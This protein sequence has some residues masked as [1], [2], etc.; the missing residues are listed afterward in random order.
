MINHNK[1][2]TPNILKDIKNPSKTD[3][4]LPP[5]IVIAERSH[6]QYPKEDGNEVVK[7]EDKQEY[8]SNKEQCRGPSDLA[9]VK[10]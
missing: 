5:N 7:D 2:R 1:I 10:Q 8:K 6:E 3:A 4:R 9:Q